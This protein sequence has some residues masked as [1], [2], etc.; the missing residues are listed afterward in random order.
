MSEHSSIIMLKKGIPLPT[1]A[2]FDMFDL[3]LLNKI[4]RWMVFKLQTDFHLVSCIDIESK[5]PIICPVLE[6][7]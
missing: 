5:S 6:V 4:T 3:F 2:P 7:L 1:G